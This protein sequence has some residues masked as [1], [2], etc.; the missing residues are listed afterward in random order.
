MWKSL[1][2]WACCLRQDNNLFLDKLES[3]LVW[4][5]VLTRFPCAEAQCF[6]FKSSE[7][8]PTVVRMQTNVR[9]QTSPPKERNTLLNAT[10]ALAKTCLLTQSKSWSLYI[11]WSPSALLF[12]PPKDKLALTFPTNRVAVPCSAVLAAPRT[13]PSW[14]QSPQPHSFRLSFWT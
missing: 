11:W 5:E 4:S 2:W 10:A 8:N 1:P 14:L 12:Q 13:L 7:K 3:L 9:L 6:P